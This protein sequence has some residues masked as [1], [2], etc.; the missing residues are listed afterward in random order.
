MV[1][2]YVKVNIDKIELIIRNVPS[3]GSAAS[4]VFK[5]WSV[6]RALPKFKELVNI[7]DELFPKN[8]RHQKVYQVKTY[9]KWQKRVETAFGLII[10][11]N[12]FHAIGAALFR[13][14]FYGVPMEELPYQ[15]WYPFDQNNPTIFV[16]L[17]VWQM[18]CIIVTLL[19]IGGLHYFMYAS[20]SLVSMYFDNLCVKLGEVKS[21][22]KTQAKS[23]ILE[24]VKLHET[25][26]GLTA[27]L[28]DIYSS[29]LFINILSGSIFIC[30]SSFK[31]WQDLSFANVEKL[32]LPL[33][34]WLFAVFLACF[35]GQ[36][37]IDANEKVGNA[38]YD[39][40]DWDDSDKDT[41]VMLLMMMQRSQKPNVM[42]AM[43]AAEVS[44]KLFTKVS[45]F[46]VPNF[47]AS[48]PCLFTD[49][50]C[51]LLLRHNSEAHWRIHEVIE[52]ASL[53]IDER[54]VSGSSAGKSI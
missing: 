15:L 36:K 27:S 52:T 8:S 14:V 49:R 1:I 48:F 23:K 4:F 26:L 10:M 50:I 41:K 34:M 53:G 16:C 32:L 9:L 18:F 29:S 42:K 44:L 17:L 37:L 38:A 6:L 21:L 31:L 51:L 39:S 19:S 43:N 30:L 22:P 24:L 33:M 5:I 35:Y 40:I 45:D 28:E 20:V 7:L 54:F 12:I 13:K 2:M 11:T 46:D 25:L 47:L 3:T